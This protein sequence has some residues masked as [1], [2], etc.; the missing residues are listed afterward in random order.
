MSMRQQRFVD[1]YIISG[2]ATQA[3]IKAGYSEKTAGRIAGQ[4]LKKLEIKAY[5]DEKMTEL[6]AKNIMSAEEALSILS[7]IA[8]G[9]RD[10]EVLMMDPTTGDV[11][12][13]TKKA[14]NATV[15]KAIQE[16]LKRY[17][18]TKQAKKLELEIERLQKELES[19]HTSERL[20]IVDSFSEEMKGL[21][22]DL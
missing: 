20:I 3:A 21:I 22:D 14:D 9:K 19:G 2:N 8:R 15:I 1:E 17:P 16:L 12:R 11:R 18:T 7:D 10:E 4:N 5:L 6:Q 13:L